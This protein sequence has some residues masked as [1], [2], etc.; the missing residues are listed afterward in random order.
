M[1]PS[2]KKLILASR[3]PRR[4][5]LL[6]SLG[7]EFE[8]SPSQ[9]KE[10]TDPAQSPENNALNIARDKARWV[11]RRNPGCY[12]LGADT[13]VVLGREII[14]QPVDKEDAFRIL[15]KLA[16]KQHKVITGVVLITP[17]NNEYDTAIVSTVTIKP[18]SAE[19][20]RSYIS[21]EE[22]L[23]KAGAYAIQGEG[24][25]LVESWEGS[26]S[27]IVGL[28]LEAL[29]DLMQQAGFSVDGTK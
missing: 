1:P 11:A 10:I 25:V 19:G 9:V 14:G 2:I 15:S 29:A 28:P 22:P 4:S 23:D 21:T 6:R 12:V 27:N 24:S 8:V 7:L 16:G 13:I 26:Y 18:V 17:E 5:E 3:S 20:I